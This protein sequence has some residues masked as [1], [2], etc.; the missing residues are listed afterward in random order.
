MLDST[1]LTYIRASV[2][3]L[4]QHGIAITQAFY[5]RLF[6]AEP[7]LL[8]IF[9][10]SNQ[11]KGA[12][13]NSLAAAVHAYA[14]YIEQPEVLMPM[15][16]RIAHKHA[17]LEVK[18]E[19]YPIVGTHLLAALQE[20]LGDAATP[21]LLDAWAKAYGVLA[22]IMIGAEADIY[23]NI[24]NTQGGW[25]GFMP[26]KVV[27]KVKESASITSFYLQKPD[28]S[29]LPT[30]KA[31]QYI[32]VRVQLGDWQHIRQYSLSDAP[33]ANTYRISVK[34]EQN[35]HTPDNVSHHLH[36]KIQEGMTIEAHAPCGD[37]FVDDEKTTPLVLISAG[38][39]QTPLFAMLAH[40]V[41]T[42]PQRP[43]VYLHAARDAAHHAF[44]A[45][46]FAIAQAHPAM[47][48]L[49]FYETHQGEASLPSHIQ[50]GRITADILAQSIPKNA[51]CYYCGPIAFMQA[52]DALLAAQG[53]ELAQR[54]YEVFGPHE[55]VQ[56]LAQGE[57]AV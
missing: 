30:F 56:Q 55:S 2:P 7:Q 1:S 28:A 49:A 25:E 24:S 6:A 39:G 41:K 17:S 40:I 16:K 32:S 37:F 54:H 21:A 10:H 20:V 8:N 57:V 43:I 34:H 36:Q 27:R 13:A 15:V 33:Q 29:V 46:V 38:V 51:E 35:P 18:P 19:H 4:E 45:A 42:Q 26:L 23:Q 48:Y 52:V 44:D 22:D 31:G 9:S 50:Q 5:R 47:Q 14:K 11:Q 53:I 3:V 12:Q